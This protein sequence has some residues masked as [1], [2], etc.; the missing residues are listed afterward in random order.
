MAKSVPKAM[1]D[2]AHTTINGVLSPTPSCVAKMNTAM[3]STMP[4]SQV[5][6]S[7]MC[8]T[9]RSHNGIASAAHRK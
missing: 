7:P 9:S 2:R 5:R 1:P 3:L 6:A 8:L 4:A